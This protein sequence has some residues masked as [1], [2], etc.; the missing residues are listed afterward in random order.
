[1]GALAACEACWARSRTIPEVPTPPICVPSGA[2]TGPSLSSHKGGR[3]LTGL[4]HLEVAMTGGSPSVRT[5]K[6]LTPG[7][8]D[9]TPARPA[10]TSGRTD[11]QETAWFTSRKEV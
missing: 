8:H 3:W 5:A 6:C 9:C 10:L 4:H 1:M 11:G 7:S 2:V